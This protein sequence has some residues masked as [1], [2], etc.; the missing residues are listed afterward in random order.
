MIVPQVVV[1]FEMSDE[2]V[3]QSL[4]EQADPQPVEEEVK[5][6]EKKLNE[7]RDFLSVAE[8]E[9]NQYLIRI[10]VEEDD[11]KIFLNFC[12]AIENSV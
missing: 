9:F 8:T 11:S 4:Y 6:M 3:F 5:E 1:A 7:Y 2:A 12:D 10:N